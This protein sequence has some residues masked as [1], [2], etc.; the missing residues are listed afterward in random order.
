MENA[1]EFASREAFRSWLEE[2]CQ[3]SGGVWLLLGKAGG[4]RTIRA[5][6]ALEE[7]LCFGWID[8]QMQRVDEGSF[9]RAGRKA[10]GRRKIRPWSKALRNGD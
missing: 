4:P 5:A 7:A 6:E 1:L 8:G 2:H 9:R 10:G 3:S